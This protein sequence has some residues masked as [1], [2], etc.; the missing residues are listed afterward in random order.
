MMRRISVALCLMFVARASQAQ[1]VDDLNRIIDQGLNHSQVMQTAE[2]LMDRIGGRLTN[3]PQMRQAE[4]WTQAQFRSW[5]LA[6]VRKEG[7]AFG[8]GWSIVS[9]SVRM[10][11][12]RTLQ[13]T[14]IPVA[15]TPATSGAI[16]APIVV[17]PMKR[18]R[19]FEAW[20]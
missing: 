18:E 12:P 17:A 14:A 15:W 5:G 8:R 4:A 20:R 9:S 3:S 19:D 13:L 7:F 1:Q 2:Y 16:S 11:A 10:I 6:N